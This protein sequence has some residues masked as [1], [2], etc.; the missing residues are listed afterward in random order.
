MKLI[1]CLILFTCSTIFPQHAWARCDATH[2]KPVKP[3]MV[4]VNPAGEIS[5]W[6][7]QVANPDELL[8]KLRS[9]K[10]ACVFVIVNENTPWKFVSNI[11]GSM[12]EHG[13]F[14][15]AAVFENGRITQSYKVLRWQS[16]D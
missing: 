4:T 16:L 10:D 14:G 9:N 15:P 3:L 7:G 2:A 12:S 5:T 1:G 8:A 13:K 6:S 11:I